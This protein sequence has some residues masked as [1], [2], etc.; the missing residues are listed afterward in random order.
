MVKKIMIH[1]NMFSLNQ[2]IYLAHDT[3]KIDIIEHI[4]TEELVK[5][6]YGIIEPNSEIEEIELDQKRKGEVP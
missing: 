3:G 5:T 1:M 2:S 4:P 6:I